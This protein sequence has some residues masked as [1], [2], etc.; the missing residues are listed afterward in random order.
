MKHWS[1]LLLVAAILNAC[2]TLKAPEQGA[3]ALFGAWYYRES[4]GGFTGKG[5]DWPKNGAISITFKKNGTFTR[6]ENDKVV[7]TD[8]YH[9]TEGVSIYNNQ[10]QTLLRFGDGSLK[11]FTISG[12]TLE[13]KD[14]VH[15]GYTYIFIKNK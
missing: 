6:S 12:D 5:V 11:S 14:E 8:S 4:S 7:E 10:K 13:L 3:K 2:S 1:L 15:D 9:F